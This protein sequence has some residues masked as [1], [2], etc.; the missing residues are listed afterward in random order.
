MSKD[1]YDDLEQADGNDLIDEQGRLWA[2]I[3]Q[4]LGEQDVQ[5]LTDFEEITIELTRREF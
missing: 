3:A 1:V 5:V 4:A 2:I